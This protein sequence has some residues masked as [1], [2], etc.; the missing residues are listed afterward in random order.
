M[1]ENIKEITK[2]EARKLVGCEYYCHTCEL[3][4]TKEDEDG[5]YCHLCAIKQA[6]KLVY[7]IDENTV[8]II[9]TTDFRPIRFVCD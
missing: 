7:D 5:L 1:F 2:E 3:N 8:Y 6:S 4:K 9:P